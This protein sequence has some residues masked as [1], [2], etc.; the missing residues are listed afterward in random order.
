MKCCVS[1]ETSLCRYAS[2]SQRAKPSNFLGSVS[3]IFSLEV[4]LFKILRVL[5]CVVLPGYALSGDRDL[6]PGYTTPVKSIQNLCFKFD[7]TD[8]I[9]SR[10]KLIRDGSLTSDYIKKAAAMNPCQAFC[11]GTWRFC[12]CRSPLHPNSIPTGH[13]SGDPKATSF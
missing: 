11:C 10:R 12:L 13:H 6:E 8:A 3:W 2:T 7:L 9:C 4:R 1:T 5:Q